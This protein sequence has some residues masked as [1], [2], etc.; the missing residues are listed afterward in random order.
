MVNQAMGKRMRRKEYKVIA[1]HTVKVKAKPYRITKGE[2]VYALHNNWRSIDYSIK[3]AEEQV[4]S[5]QKAIL[6]LSAEK[7]ET[8][9]RYLKL[10]GERIPETRSDEI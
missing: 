7:K 3:E 4:Q 5:A 10:T 9:R 1:E 2:A 6:S 8:E